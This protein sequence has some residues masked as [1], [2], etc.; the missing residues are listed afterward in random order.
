MNY[1]VKDVTINAKF[2]GRFKEMTVWKRVTQY[3]HKEKKNIRNS[4]LCERSVLEPFICQYLSGLKVTLLVNTNEILKDD[5]FPRYSVSGLLL[6]PSF[7]LHDTN[8]QM[9]L[10]QGEM[11]AYNIKFHCRIQNLFITILDTSI[12][13]DV[14][15]HEDIHYFRTRMR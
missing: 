5:T 6:Q 15:K 13:I 7:I 12:Y 2:Y 3:L 8:S 1:M 11:G 9:K 14:Q 10:I 4:V